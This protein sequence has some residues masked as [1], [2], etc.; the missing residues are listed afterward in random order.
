MPFSDFP[1]NKIVLLKPRPAKKAMEIHSALSDYF[2]AKNAQGNSGKR[3]ARIWPSGATILIGMIETLVSPQNLY[4][5]FQYISIHSA[6][7]KFHTGRTT[8]SN[9]S[10]KT[11]TVTQSEK[12]LNTSKTTSHCNHPG[13]DRI[14]K[15]K[16]KQLKWKHLWKISV[17]STWGDDVGVRNTGNTGWIPGGFLRTWKMDF[18]HL[19][20]LRSRRPLRTLLGIL[21]Y[22]C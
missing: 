14:R 20:A 12:V 8:T 17:L 10:G 13:A 4:D 3:S 18:C 7:K 16:N 22:R 6:A 15:F 2:F 5:T 19:E 21:V 1:H 11:L 9:I